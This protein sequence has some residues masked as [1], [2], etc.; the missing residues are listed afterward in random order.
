MTTLELD[1]RTIHGVGDFYEQINDVF[2]RGES[3]TLGPSLDALNDVL[4][5]GYG[6][7]HGLRDEFP[8]TL[9]WKDHE[10][11][12]A[13]LGKDARRAELRAKLRHPDRF[14]VALVQKD[15]DE[16]DNGAGSS[17]F[18]LVLE[19]FS[20]HESRIGLVLR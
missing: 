1:G 4:G 10:L 13:A 11:A 7:L 3:W 20:Q 16:Y 8:V 5:G 12:R 19:V 9:V 6:V 18:D 15:L 14:D 17:Y 2:M